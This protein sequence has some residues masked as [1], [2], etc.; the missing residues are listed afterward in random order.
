MLKDLEIDVGTMY[1]ELQKLSQV[2]DAN[3]KATVQSVT[4]LQHK[5]ESALQD[6]LAAHQLLPK[7]IQ[8]VAYCLAKGIAL[9]RPQKC[10]FLEGPTRLA[11]QV[12]QNKLAR[13]HWV[14]DL[15][16]QN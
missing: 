9:S 11:M 5:I 7:Q 13:Y 14:I 6:R 8:F 12:H 2:D 10:L 4:H 3:R 1:E 15:T 16:H